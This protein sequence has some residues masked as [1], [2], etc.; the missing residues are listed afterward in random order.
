M[1]SALLS[2]IQKCDVFVSFKKSDT[3]KS[4]VS[5]LYRSLNRKGITTFK[6]DLKLPKDK[7]FHMLQ[8]IG[9]PKIA[10]IV[11][12]VNY[13]SSP[14]CMSQLTEILKFM[15]ASALAVIP[16]FYE[17][18]PSNSHSITETMLSTWSRALTLLASLPGEYTDYWTILT[19]TYGKKMVNPQ[20]DKNLSH[21]R[22]D[23]A[24]LIEKVTD[25]ICEKLTT[26][27]SCDYTD[28]FG[29]DCHMKALYAMLDL[30]SN[31]QDV[32]KVVAI[33]GERGVGKTTFAKYAY[34]EILHNFHA[35][36]FM[37]NIYKIY[38]GRN[39]SRLQ[40]EFLSKLVIQTEALTIKNSKDGSD[41]VKSRL[42]HRKVL[43]IADGVVTMEQVEDVWKVACWLG[44][45]SRVII[46][47]QDCSLLVAKG[48]QNVY[49]VKRLRYDEALQF[50][51]QFA[52]KQQPPYNHFKQLSVRA[53]KLAG[54][55]PLSLKILGS[56]LNGKGEKD[57]ESVLQRL[58]AEND[59]E[60]ILDVVESSEKARRWSRLYTLP[61]KDAAYVIRGNKNKQRQQSID[62]LD[63]LF[64]FNQDTNIEEGSGVTASEVFIQSPEENSVHM[65]KGRRFYELDCIPLWGTVSIQGRR[66]EMEDA[67]AVLPHFLQLPFKMLMG[68]HEGMSP[69]LTHLTGHF[70]GVYDGHGGNQVADYCRDRL[71]FALS[72]EMERRKDELCKRNTGEGR[73]VQWEKVFTSCFLTVDGEVEG[74]IGRAV[75]G[76]S[77]KVLEAVFSET[78]GSTALVALVCSSH[79]V[80]SNCGDS[81]AVLLRGHEAMP[82]S[83][84]HKPDRED[85]YARI[86]NA[87]GRVIQWPG[88][89]ALVLGVHQM[90][91]SIGDRFLKPYMIPEPEVTF[92]QRSREDECLILASDGLWDVMN[93]EDACE[94]ARRRILMWHKKNSAPP[95][96]GRGKGTDPACQAAADYLS[97]LA[98]EKGSK[99][100]ISIIVIDLKAQRKFKTRT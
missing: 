5:H 57:W 79:I 21:D 82:L 81:R 26:S 1:A 31:N 20:N 28:L 98:L 90:S 25:D 61:P 41:V 45:G 4:F 89:G 13:I 17:I 29:M 92:T 35:Y 100:N 95:L 14:W 19:K 80:V 88:A 52:F 70:F 44:Q 75:V 18:D 60:K 6:D 2:S 67:I 66:S 9:Y 63:L 69:S 48:L 37:E 42:L 99:D 39:P 7:P 94:M 49:E 23:D 87:G 33:F 22:D 27:T 10:L 91:R 50:F 11:V 96:A 77:D 34:E 24:G 40:E 72:E 32:Q 38:Q 97:M 93:N 64:G 8:D 73:Q 36:I 84:D 54:C 43:F 76:S 59:E 53:T 56:F 3:G 12:S 71:H 55:L 62:G 86:E 16:I 74:K 83:V 68:D 30:G 65:V 51:Y 78:V 46:T 85:E 58:E 47:T 15:K